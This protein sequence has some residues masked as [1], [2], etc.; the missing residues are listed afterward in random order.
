MSTEID[1]EVMKLFESLEAGSAERR[2]VR[3]QDGTM[4]EGRY[5]TDNTTGHEKFE[6]YKD[7]VDALFADR[8]AYQAILKESPRHRLIL[9]MT[10]NGQSP[11]DIASALGIT[12]QTVY[13]T[14]KQPWFREM[15]TRLTTSMGKDTV[16]QF[17][18]SEV[19]P[20]L[21]VLRDIRDDEN[22]KPS[23]RRAAADSMLDRYLGKATV[24]VDSAAKAPADVPA[25]A[26]A[27][28]EEQRRLDAEIKSR[29][30]TYG[31]PGQS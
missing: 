12:K 11:A 25:E 19:M 9:W 27:L 2:V 3:K 10:A 5:V 31:R 16:T 30:L 8:P 15:F 26:A 13:I 7:S 17:L 24:K 6:E 29:G 1:P 14:R 20:S 4:G 28:L 23:D 18:S 21:E 22:A